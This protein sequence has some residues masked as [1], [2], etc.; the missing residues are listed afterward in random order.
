MDRPSGCG[1][2]L[3]W[4]HAAKRQEFHLQLC[5][6]IVQK[7]LV[8]RQIVASPTNQTT[9]SRPQLVLPGRSLSLR[10]AIDARHLN[11]LRGAER[12]GVQRGCGEI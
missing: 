5:V 8:A 11:E 12:R 7:H 3:H 10:I 4:S 1:A 2:P 6:Q 9:T